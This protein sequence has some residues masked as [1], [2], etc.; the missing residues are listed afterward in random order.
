MSKRAR[1]ILSLACALT[2]SLV[3]L[4][5]TGHVRDEAERTRTEAMRRYG[6]EVVS[7][8]VA[9]HAIGAG[10]V[11]A[12]KD[13]EMRDWLASL[14][15][16]GAMTSLDDVVGVEVSVPV[17]AGAPLT[18]LNFRDPSE[19]ADIPSGHVAVSVPI[20]EKLGV[21][22]MT[23]V[24]THVVAYR[25]V[26]GAAELIGS[27]ATVLAAPGSTGSSMGR[28][29]ITIAVAAK[30]VPAV[31]AAST[32]GDLRLVVPADDVAELAKGAAKDGD[33]NVPPADG[34]GE[35][36]ASSEREGA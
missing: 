36:K 11:V 7:L 23:G 9:T 18:S 1:V 26:D 21:T 24:G 27:D 15:P 5:Y 2:A 30:D 12:T 14:A 32:S 3:C 6:G 35:A 29:T 20:T 25:T 16:E 33:E 28:G 13:V 31:L 22:A 34:A 17:A 10:E 19:M 8:A 4:A